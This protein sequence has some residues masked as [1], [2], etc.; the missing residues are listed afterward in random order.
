MATWKLARPSKVCALTGRPLAPGA[1]VVTALFGV[2][3]E[4]SE[5]RVRGA[6]FTRRDFLA[7]D[8]P[9]DALAGA[10]ADA[11]CVWR[12]KV[13]LDTG[14]KVMRLDVAMA[15][16]LLER[17]VREDDPSRASAAWTLAMLL[18]RKRQL[19]LVADRDGRLVLRWPKSETTFEVPS[20]VVPEAEMERLEQ[21]LSRLFEV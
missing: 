1:S 19:T 13:P 12:T 10:L 7:D 16:D 14:P 17:I 20:V 11:Y 2:D 15:R 6:G 9:A 8:V 18:V 3:E 5:D 4:V 21:D